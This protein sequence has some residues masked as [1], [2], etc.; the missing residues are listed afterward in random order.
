M[1]DFPYTAAVSPAKL[2]KLVVAMLEMHFGVSFMIKAK[3]QHDNWLFL[4]L[5][6]TGNSNDR[7]GLYVVHSSG[8]ASNGKSLQFKV[9]REDECPR[10]GAKCPQEILD[11][12][13]MF[14][15]E[16]A[17]AE[18]SRTYNESMATLTAG[19]FD[20]V[21]LCHGDGYQH[22]HMDIK[23]VAWKKREIVPFDRLRVVALDSA[24]EGYDLDLDSA[25]MA[26]HGFSILDPR[27]YAPVFEAKGAGELVI[28]GQMVFQS[29]GSGLQVVG[30]E[31]TPS[32][33]KTFRRDRM[34]S[35]HKVATENAVPT[36]LFL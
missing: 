16:S 12:T 9:F 1:F 14:R 8:T 17:F 22:P 30:T 24:G 5:I 31:P 15:T 2:P 13:S 18:V 20:S 32:Q 10:P 35:R 19:S 3:H 21:Y 27:A 26:Q 34:A 28:L 7:S 29:T 25:S 36:L 6:N 33:L 23:I 4:A 11:V